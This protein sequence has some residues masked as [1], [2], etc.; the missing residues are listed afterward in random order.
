MDSP[1]PQ[2]SSRRPSTDEST[3]EPLDISFGV[4]FEFILIER[5]PNWKE[6]ETIDY[7]PKI[8]H[9]LS[10]AGDVLKDTWFQC[11][12]KYCNE[13]FR[14]PIGVEPPPIDRDPTD[15]NEDVPAAWKP[16]HSHWNVVA[17]NSM[18]LSLDQSTAL[19]EN[20]YNMF[21][22]EV[23]SR[24]LFFDR[25]APVLSNDATTEHEHT[26]TAAE[27]INTVLAALHRAFDSP[28]RANGGR[29]TQWL[30]INDTCELH[31]HVGNDD[32]GF[33]L[34]TIKN[35]VSLYIAFERVIDSMHSQPRIGGTV[36]ALTALDALDDFADEI[37]KDGALSREDVVRQLPITAHKIYNAT[38]TE[39]FIARAWCQRRNRKNAPQ[40]QPPKTSRH[41][42]PGVPPSQAD[43]G[44]HTTAFLEIIQAA[45]CLESLFSG[46]DVDKH[47]NVSLVYLL[48][49][50]GQKTFEFRGHAAVQPHA[51]PFESR[52]HAAATAPTETLAFVEFCAALV[53]YA[54]EK[55]AGLV[56]AICT[57][58]AN[59]PQLKLQTLLALIRMRDETVNY[60]VDRVDGREPFHDHVAARSEMENAFGDQGGD[61]P[62]RRVALE[63][64][65]ERRTEFDRVDVRKATRQKFDVGGYGQF[66]RGF[67]DMYAPDLE[68]EQKVKL[69][70]G[71]DAPAVTATSGMPMPRARSLP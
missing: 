50:M 26:I 46:D 2:H 58:A 29:K 71:W 35:V 36:L 52:Q 30:G 39:H 54:H 34:Q 12:N 19:K 3:P 14:M 62:M 8:F 63:L 6:W 33:P 64:I 40:R 65:D 32:K 7:R 10:R 60:W 37:D 11:N 1:K 43:Y 38:L 28:A 56:R 25:D 23:T 57:R 31:V 68:E 22:V 20:H 9:G 55:D 45:P 15:D 16:D 27:E 4:E 42:P 21:G 67:I 49:R 44:L 48:E 18:K 70:I 53:K 59:N 69:T 66:S 17:D 61:G 41:A 47:S 24:K 13:K 51:E 5:I